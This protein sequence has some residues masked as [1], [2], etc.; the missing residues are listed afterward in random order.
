MPLWDQVK[1][2]L[3]EWYTV[4]ADKT[5]ELAKIGVRRYDKFG[6]SRDVER[7]FTELGSFVYNALAEGR[8]DF[9]AD[10]TL[11]AI[12]ERI[13]GLERDLLQKEEEIEEIRRIHREKVS[14][15]EDGTST[16]KGATLDVD[17]AGSGAV[18]GV[19]GESD[20]AESASGVSEGAETAED[21]RVAPEG[22]PESEET[23][24]REKD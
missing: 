2:N 24:P 5:E 9:L 8:Q 1:T 17:M 12:V 19:G 14:H 7:Q 15:K 6:I 21:H 11:T 23:D 4:A 13:K 20:Q 16:Q 18:A 3:V 22:A 10:P